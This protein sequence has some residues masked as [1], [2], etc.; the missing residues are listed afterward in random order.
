MSLINRSRVEAMLKPSTA[1]DI[2]SMIVGLSLFLLWKA[3][4]EGPLKWLCYTAYEQEIATVIYTGQIIQWLMDGPLLLFL[5]APAIAIQVMRH[6]RVA[7]TA[8][9]DASTAIL[10][11]YII[12]MEACTVVT[13]LGYG[14]PY[15]LNMACGYS[16][17]LSGITMVIYRGWKIE[18]TARKPSQA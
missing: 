11:C 12:W 8:E 1:L 15:V 18:R 17:I 5:I 2:F 7:R 9:M 14:I 4:L 16:L 10:T 3:I 13:M 6:G